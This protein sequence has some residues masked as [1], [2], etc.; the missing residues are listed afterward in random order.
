MNITNKWKPFLF[1]I[2]FREWK[3]VYTE[4]KLNI[5]YIW[6][7]VI[8]NSIPKKSVYDYIRPTY[9]SSED[10]LRKIELELNPG[11]FIDWPA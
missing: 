7:P 4:W 1:H 5:G 3:W 6:G 8:W 9:A 2:D 11:N 10:G